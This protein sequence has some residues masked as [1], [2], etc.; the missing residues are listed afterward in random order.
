MQSYQVRKVQSE[1]YSGYKRHQY[2]E[3]LDEKGI[4]YAKRIFNRY[5][6]EGV[7]EKGRFEDDIWEMTDEVRN[8]R[9]DFKAD[10]AAYDKGA[11]SWTGIPAGCFTEQLKAF[12][13][14]GM[15]KYALSTLASF[16]QCMKRI[17][18]MDGSAVTRLRPRDITPQMTDFLSMA[19]GG[20]P[21]MERICEMM[22]ERYSAAVWKRRDPR[23][24]GDFRD[25][26]SFDRALRDYW[27]QAGS[28]EKTEYF[29]VWFWWNLT[30]I[31][32][33]RPTEYLM[34]PWECLSRDGGKYILAVRR[35]LQK[36]SGHRYSYH[37]RDDYGLYHYQ[38]PEKIAH[39]VLEYRKNTAS[40]R[41]ADDWSLCLPSGKGK[42][43]YL[44]YSQ[45]KTRLG[46]FLRRIGKP[47]LGIR[48]GDTRHLAMISLIL[49]GGSPEICRELAGHED[50]DIS[51]HYYANIPSLIESAVYEQSHGGEPGVMFTGSLCALPPV[52]GKE[53][54]RTAGGWC[55]F[56]GA[57]EGD[58]SECMKNYRDR[59]RLGEC[60]DCIH[61]YPSGNPLK[62]K[63]QG[64]HRKAVEKDAE[65]LVRMIDAV[66]KGLGHE[67]EIGAA[68]DRLASSGQAYASC[69]MKGEV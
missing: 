45:L 59:G 43:G 65:F 62:L 26:F 54:I 66:R 33:L 60:G 7:I 41:K 8:Y 53:L 22:E 14:L 12:I 36:K 32:P 52:Q 17:M 63:V 11:G 35:T 48:L 31:L 23:S 16:L 39:A 30:A 29:P 68:M 27:E 25:Y 37:I 2:I 34:T 6:I 21:S 57:F 61:F 19:S 4:R 64:E 42:M 20:E 28:K 15:G 56:P 10:E 13:S 40:L 44:T 18:A 51:S 38:V 50:I 69:L 5:R 49:S 58:I 9:F 3:T 47:D 67:E 55:D 46:S 1:E 24:L